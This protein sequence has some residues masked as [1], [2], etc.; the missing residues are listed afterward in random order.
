MLTFAL[1]APTDSRLAS[2]L[3]ETHI[4][5]VPVVRQLPRPFPRGRGSAAW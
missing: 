4:Y 5:T 2:R 1:A 3:P